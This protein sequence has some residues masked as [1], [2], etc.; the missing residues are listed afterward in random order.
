MN[1]GLLERHLAQAERH[2]TEGSIHVERQRELV[3]QL[4]RK[5]QDSSGARS[6]LANFEDVLRMHIAD[7]DR[8]ATEL[9]GS[10]AP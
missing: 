5:G 3:Q 1:R 8:L 7:R 6:L 2:V 9:A 10:K 4:E